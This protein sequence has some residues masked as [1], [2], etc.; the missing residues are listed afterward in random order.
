MTRCIGAEATR[1][2]LTFF[3]DPYHFIERLVKRGGAAGFV[4]PIVEELGL[5]KIRGIG[6]STFQGGEIFESIGHLHVLID[7]PRDGFF[8][9]LRPETGETMPPAWVPEDVTSYTSIHWD[10]EN[11]YKNFG[12]IMEKF[13][14]QEFLKNMIEDPINQALDVSVP[15]EIKETLA[16]RYVSCRWIQPPIKLNSQV[17]V[18]AFSLKDTP[19]AKEIVAKIRSR[20]SKRL[21]VDS[22]GGQVVYKI[23]TPKRN[24]PEGLRVPEPCFV[25]VKDW[26]VFSDSRKFLERTLQASSDSMPRLLN[27]L[28]YELVSSELGGKL[29]GEEPFMLSF[30][31]GSDYIRQI[32]ELGQ[33]DDTLRFLRKQ[34]ESNPV[35]KQMVDL[36]T[37]NELPPFEKFK[38]YFAPSGTFAYDEPSG[39][40]MGSF[41]L[42]AQE[43]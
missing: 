3:L 20:Y 40:H 5:G 34:G 19:R 31:R 21:E 43:D 33:S 28:Q 25:I 6:G 35:I 1:P 16:G 8:G 30:L 42:R 24:M 41:T 7:P 10:L 32:Y 17:Q 37:R 23:M 9:V 14:G 36:L 39:I 12:K 13:R 22:F 4:W 26:L 38:K 2:Q 11:T 18:H 29:N 27:N 15:V